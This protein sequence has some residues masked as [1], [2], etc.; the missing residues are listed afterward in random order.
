MTCPIISWSSI[1]KKQY[2]CSWFGKPKKQ[3]CGLWEA[4]IDDLNVTQKQRTFFTIV[5]SMYSWMFEE[6]H[7]EINCPCSQQ[8]MHR[9]RSNSTSFLNSNKRSVLDYKVK[10]VTSIVFH[11]FQL[12]FSDSGHSDSDEVFS[13]SDPSSPGT[14]Q[15]EIGSMK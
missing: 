13:D 6:S 15:R 3:L 14:S 7:G 1:P 10:N 11:Q 2:P 8:K 5:Q 4:F 9:E 12:S